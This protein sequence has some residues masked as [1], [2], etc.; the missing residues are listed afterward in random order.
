M[1]E[2]SVGHGLQILLQNCKACIQRESWLR[3]RVVED[4]LE[5]AFQVGQSL[6]IEVNRHRLHIAFALAGFAVALH[7]PQRHHSS[8][9]LICLDRDSD[10]LR[11]HSLVAAQK[12]LYQRVIGL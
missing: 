6:A 2:V 11:G 5:G 1:P 10:R 3:R 7:E 12:L 4:L 9:R 8:R